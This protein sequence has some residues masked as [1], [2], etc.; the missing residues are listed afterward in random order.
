MYFKCNIDYRTEHWPFLWLFPYNAF[1][2]SL[3]VWEN[4]WA[5]F[6]WLNGSWTLLNTPPPLTPCHYLQLSADLMAISSSFSQ[7]ETKHTCRN[8]FGQLVRDCTSKCA[9]PSCLSWLFISST[10]QLRSWGEMRIEVLKNRQYGSGRH[11]LGDNENDW[12]RWDLCVFVQGGLGML[13]VGECWE[14]KAKNGSI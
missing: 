8:T 12:A 1:S 7:S 3:E 11:S 13:Y 6:M 14:I 5:L 2:C 9:L 4:N 10:C